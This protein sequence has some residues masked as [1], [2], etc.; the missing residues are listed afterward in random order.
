V[1]QRRRFFGEGGS[2]SYLTFHDIFFVSSFLKFW[3]L[4]A[5]NR[6]RVELVALASQVAA[7]GFTPASASASSSSSSSSSSASELSVSTAADPTSPTVGSYD[8]Y[9][10]QSSHT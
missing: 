6:V 4:C 10:N 1:Q 5:G 9:L 8:H 3:P 2:F 7:A